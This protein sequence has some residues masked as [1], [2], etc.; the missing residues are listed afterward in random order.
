MLKKKVGDE[1]KV[2]V[3]K[4]FGVG[5]RVDFIEDMTRNGEA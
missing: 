1:G 2:G 5:E 4:E 3:E